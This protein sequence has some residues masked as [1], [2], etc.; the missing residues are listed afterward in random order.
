MSKHFAK[1]QDEFQHRRG[2]IDGSH[3]ALPGDS[4]K[5]YREG[6]KLGQFNY[7]KEKY[8]ETIARTLKAERDF[9]EKISKE[10]KQKEKEGP[11]PRI[12]APFYSCPICGEEY[13]GYYCYGCGYD[14]DYDD[15]EDYDNYSS[16]EEVP[17][18]EEEN[19]KDEEEEK[20]KALMGS[21]GRL[22]ISKYTSPERLQR[23]MESG[24]LYLYTGVTFVP[25]DY[26]VRYRCDRCGHEW[27]DI[28]PETFVS[29]K[30]FVDCRMGCSNGASKPTLL[31][32]LKIII[33]LITGKE[34]FGYGR[35]IKSEEL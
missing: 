4:N 27:D 32:F 3:G 34:P 18:D 26:L 19:E 12:E 10:T 15:D 14:D 33:G 20:I 6:Y 11:L 1:S 13:D 8:G 16:Q 22:Y 17:G 30:T 23:I 5:K 31:G 29:S 21:S 9:A 28:I 7:E 24:E 25:P 2:Q 35:L